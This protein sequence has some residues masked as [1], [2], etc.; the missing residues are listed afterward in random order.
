[1]LLDRD[2]RIDVFDV[3]YVA[4]VRPFWVRSGIRRCTPFD[5]DPLPRDVNKRLVT[6]SGGFTTAP[7]GL[8][9]FAVADFLGFIVG[10]CDEEVRIHDLLPGRLTRNGEPKTDGKQSVH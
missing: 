10:S 2:W 9:I 7:R 3:L 4:D 5:A 6:T 8:A 1:K